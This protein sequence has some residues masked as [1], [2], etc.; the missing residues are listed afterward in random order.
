MLMDEVVELLLQ[1]KKLPEKKS[2]HPLHGNWKG[3]REC[4]IQTDWLQS[5]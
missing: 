5:P 3:F 4:H 1:G 2:D